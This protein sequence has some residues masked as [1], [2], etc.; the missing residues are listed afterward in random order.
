MTHEK[1][2]TEELS[3]IRSLLPI[4][5]AIIGSVMAW[6]LNRPAEWR[7]AFYTSSAVAF[8]ALWVCFT[9]LMLWRMYRLFKRLD[10][11]GDT[12]HDQS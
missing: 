8:I 9:V 6:L 5:A 2:V 7:T 1:R 11:L 10:T 3:V 4:V 12:H